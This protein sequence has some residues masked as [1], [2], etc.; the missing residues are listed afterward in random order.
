MLSMDPRGMKSE[1]VVGYSVK[2]IGRVIQFIGCKQSIPRI[3][4]LDFKFRYI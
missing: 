4:H 3:R 1:V 2:I